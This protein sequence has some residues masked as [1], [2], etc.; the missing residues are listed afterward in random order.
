[1]WD[2]LRGA[3]QLHILHHAAEG[4]IYGAWMSAELADEVFDY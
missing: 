4:E 2:F 1:M 3:V